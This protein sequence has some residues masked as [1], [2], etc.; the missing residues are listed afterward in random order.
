M[1]EYKMVDTSTLKGLRAA[2]RLKANGWQ[3]Y[4]TG[5]FLVYFKRQTKRSV[6]K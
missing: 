6:S 3:I 5:L 1:I 2:E 4:R